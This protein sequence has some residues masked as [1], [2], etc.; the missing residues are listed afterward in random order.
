MDP[1]HNDNN[2]DGPDA[3]EANDDNGFEDVPPPMDDDP[4]THE[5]GP[6]EAPEGEDAI[7]GVGEIEYED[8][9]S[10]EGRDGGDDANEEEDEQYFEDG[11]DVLFLPADHPLMSRIQGALTKQLTDEHERRDLQLR[12]KEEELKKMKKGREE[13][14]VQLYGVQHQLAKMQLTFE[15]THDNFNIVQKYRVD[16]EKQ[17]EVLQKQYEQRKEE[18][19]EQLKKVL[20][21]QEELNQL[22]RTLK[23]V[24]EYNEVMKGEI[25]TTRRAAYNVEE[26]VVN[27]ERGKKKQDLLIDSMNEEIK[28]L[29][30][31][32]TLYQAQL[33]S[34]R[35]ETAA[36]RDTLQEA[37]KEIDKVVMSKKTLLSDWKNSI[38]D[39]R[40]KD[41]AFQTLKQLVKEKKKKTLRIDVEIVGAKK[42]I[43][44]EQ[45]ISERLHQR[46]SK[47]VVE[48]KF[49]GDKREQIM[50]DLKRLEE[51][52]KMLKKSLNS[53]EGELQKLEIE[54]SEVMHQMATLEKSIMTLHSKT[55]KLRDDIVNYAS[56]Q[57]TIE[58]SS[59]NLNKQTEGMYME[60]NKKEVEIE[61]IANEISRVK[62]DVLNTKTQNELLEKK[63][64]S[65]KDEL[66]R[67]EKEV[68]QNE[69]EIN[70][71]LAD[72]QKKQLEVDKLNKQLGELSSSDKQASAVPLVAKRNNI[73]KE[74][75]ETEEEIDNIK[76]EWINNQTKF[77]TNQ[78]TLIDNQ[79]SNDHYKTKRIILE[80]KKMRL[81]QNFAS[82]E[83]QIRQLEIALKNLDFDMNKQN[84]T[85]SSN[86]ERQKNLKNENF[87]LE[88]EFVQKLK[89]LENESIKLENNIQNL[90]EEK[91]DILAEIVEAE[92]QILLWERKIQLEKEMQDT[93]DPNI[94][95]S[96][97]V[98]MKQEI[99]RMELRYEQLKKKQ[100]Q[101]IKDM[102][103]AV[104]K[105]ETIQL[106]YLPKVEKKNAQDKTS[107]GKLSR[108]IA[109]LK[110]T[111]KHTTE[112]SIQLDSTIEDK[113]KELEQVNDEIDKATHNIENVE[114]QG[115][116]N[117]MKLLSLKL[118][119]Q[120]NLFDLY[121]LQTQGKRYD[122]IANARFVPTVEEEAVEQAMEEQ[123]NQNNR[124]SDILNGVLNE[125]G[126][127]EP[128]LG[129][130]VNWVADS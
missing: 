10:G 27:L 125:N 87:N 1:D 49:L 103:R 53:T 78:H 15:R 3:N 54:K 29:N 39:M 96:E 106:K 82:Q 123:K 6:T 88:N 36:A 16:S 40:Y 112:S 71:N 55:K 64:K 41:S 114:D 92:R 31:N 56:Q 98:A 124:I 2:N 23:Q 85:F 84:D 109:N 30:D 107:Q 44:A 12:E 81:N 90:K 91:A 73:E 5:L 79:T 61:D 119:R 52:K 77:V 99:H 80:Q 97:I 8:E 69:N 32:K 128:V 35:E 34:Q 108:Q 100:E 76:K 62:I 43:R 126:D 11:T 129:K 75:G 7:P 42:E 48:R 74:I 72:I 25:A 59:A 65:L 118:D 26:G 110:Q 9:E 122:E 127:L 21:A 111:L 14:G 38:K 130:L 115:H 24:E 19:D 113:V 60:I 117:N 94:G 58:K 63:F 105:R 95:Q 4:N 101:M 67:K 70:M 37:S 51:Q 116:T 18:A 89:E 50:D 28:R 121:K 86:L 17:L 57:T 66:E 102:E 20:R 104:F 83:K 68:M 46:Q 47:Y 22:N 93:L 45:N 120:H 33:I 13:V